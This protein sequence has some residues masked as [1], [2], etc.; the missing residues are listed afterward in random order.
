MHLETFKMVDKLF[1]LQPN[2]SGL[3][4]MEEHIMT[5][6]LKTFMYKFDDGRIKL[7]ELTVDRITRLW[8]L[9]YGL[10]CV[11][12]HGD[13][14]ATL[15]TGVLFQL[16]SIDSFK[17]FFGDAL[18]EEQLTTLLNQVAQ[19]GRAYPLSNLT[20]EN[21]ERFLKKFVEVFHAAFIDGVVLKHVV[22][23]DPAEAFDAA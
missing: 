10:R 1:G 16:Q 19:Q 22:K 12:Q 18:L 15:E 20:V 7:I 8:L 3:S 9:F 5:S 14:K 21:M 6:E 4:K 2:D 23:P 11:F 17:G 13:T